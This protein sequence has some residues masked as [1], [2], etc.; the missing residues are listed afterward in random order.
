MA[1]VANAAAAALPSDAPSI[2]E[3]LE[4]DPH[5]CADRRL[6][7]LFGEATGRGEALRATI[8]VAAAAGAA[9]MLLALAPA[10][11]SAA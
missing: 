11:A 8:R 4:A 1:R 6:D 10:G 9:S 2:G 5:P 7:L 3:S